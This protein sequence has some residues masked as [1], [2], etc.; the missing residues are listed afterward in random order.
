MTIDAVDA[1]DDG[2]K[3]SDKSVS[4][5]FWLIFADITESGRRA[6]VCCG[7]QSQ[8]G[9]R[10]GRHFGHYLLFFQ[11]VKNNETTKW[12]NNGFN[13]YHGWMETRSENKIETKNLLRFW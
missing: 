8:S 12:P 4:L 5:F 6:A 10:R 13:C 7:R 9:P 11:R 2:D 1:D 3:K